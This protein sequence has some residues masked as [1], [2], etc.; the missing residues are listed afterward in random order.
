MD[1]P[2]RELVNGLF[3]SF[4]FL[5]NELGLRRLLVFYKEHF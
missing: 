3:F 2:L 1:A 4:F 5:F